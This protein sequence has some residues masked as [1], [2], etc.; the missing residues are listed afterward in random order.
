MM[1]QDDLHT[2]LVLLIGVGVVAALITISELRKGTIE[3]SFGKTWFEMFAGLLGTLGILGILF[4]SLSLYPNVIL[5]VFWAVVLLV[6]GVL[7]WDK[8][9]KKGNAP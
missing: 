8:R 9:K 7:W 2:T 1:G 4:L 3:E 6:I 5:A